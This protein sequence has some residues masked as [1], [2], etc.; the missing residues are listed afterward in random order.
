MDLLG[1]SGLSAV[2]SRQ[3]ELFTENCDL[4]TALSKIYQRNAELDWPN[5]PCKLAYVSAALAYEDAWKFV[6]EVIR[7]SCAMVCNEQALQPLFAAVTSLGPGIED[8][9]D[10]RNTSVKDFDSHRRRLKGLEIKRDT[11]EVMI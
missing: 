9:C 2:L 10:E 8:I 3:K 1:G 6:N 5:V 4:A 7:T 11:L